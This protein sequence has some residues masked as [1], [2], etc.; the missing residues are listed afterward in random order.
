MGPLIFFLLV[1]AAIL[2][3]TPRHE[4]GLALGSLLIVGATIWVA[5]RINLHRFLASIVG[6][7]IALAWAYREELL[8]LFA[9]A[10]VLVVPILMIYIAV[11]DRIP[12]PSA[13]RRART[14]DSANESGSQMGRQ[15]DRL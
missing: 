13:A 5:T 15:N 9:S 4:R 14:Q 8:V 2:T 10:V 7:V 11:C 6:S 1:A 3:C 12:T